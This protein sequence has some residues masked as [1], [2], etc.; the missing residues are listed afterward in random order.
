M[1]VGGRGAE[2][3]QRP[4][5]GWYRGKRYGAAR[6]VVLGWGGVGM[7]GRRFGPVAWEKA[8]GVTGDRRERTMGGDM[9]RKKE[10]GKETMGERENT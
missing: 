2:V 10:S 4:E 7:R 1:G 8:S 5:R 9:Q 6:K 3:A